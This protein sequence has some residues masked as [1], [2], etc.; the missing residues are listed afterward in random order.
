M[1]SRVF[2]G[3][4]LGAKAEEKDLWASQIH[5]VGLRQSDQASGLC[6]EFYVEKRGG[7]MG[8]EFALV[9]LRRF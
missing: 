6:R 4:C 3:S 8:E 7:Y 9:Q 1:A 2:Q 5:R